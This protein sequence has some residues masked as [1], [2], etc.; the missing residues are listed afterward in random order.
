MNSNAGA[1][2]V[3]NVW[4]DTAPTSSVF[5]IGNYAEINTSG[6]EYIAYCWRTISSFSAFGSYNGNSASDGSG[7]TQSITTGFQP[8]WVIIKRY[9]GSEN[10]YIQDSVRGSTEQLYA[11]NDS[12]EYDETNGIQSFDSTGF[13]LGGY[14]GINASG[15]SFVYMAFKMN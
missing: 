6:G 2:T 9:D 4:N 7:T 5:S 3:S 8:D 14:N 12:P 11:N 13:T 10:W 1:Y 15:E